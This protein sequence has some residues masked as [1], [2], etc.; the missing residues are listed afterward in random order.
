[1]EGIPEG[2]CLDHLAT[3][4]MALSFAGDPK[5]F[6]F[7]CGAP[8]RRRWAS[9]PQ[10]LKPSADRRRGLGEDGIF[11]GMAKN[12]ERNGIDFFGRNLFY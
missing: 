12:V 9:N 11:T 1:M 7:C 10:A 8:R 6:K 5:T 3:P 2:K 4:M